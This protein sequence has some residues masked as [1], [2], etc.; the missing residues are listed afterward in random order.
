MNKKLM[1]EV[2][3]IVANNKKLRAKEFKKQLAN[4]PKFTD[5]PVSQRKKNEGIPVKVRKARITEKPQFKIRDSRKG[6]LKL[7]RE[8]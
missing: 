7:G 4:K 3:K 2:R 6:G 8:K 5:M 1:E